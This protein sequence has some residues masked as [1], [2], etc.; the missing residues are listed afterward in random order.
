MRRLGILKVMSYVFLKVICTLQFHKFFDC[1]VL[2][3]ISSV[4]SY[5]FVFDFHI[6]IISFM[7]RYSQ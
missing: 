2:R 1:F 3:T 4:L 6:C 7:L 5:H